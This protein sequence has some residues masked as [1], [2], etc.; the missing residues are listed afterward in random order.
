MLLMPVKEREKREKK[1]PGPALCMFFSY[2][3]KEQYLRESKM[4]TY[5]INGGES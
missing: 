1:T 5:Y 3:K 4:G 2:L